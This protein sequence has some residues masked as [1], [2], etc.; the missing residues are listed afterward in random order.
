MKAFK[1]LVSIKFDADEADFGE[2]V[3][4]LGQWE[5]CTHLAATARL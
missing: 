1:D 5:T 2:S 3:G 4:L